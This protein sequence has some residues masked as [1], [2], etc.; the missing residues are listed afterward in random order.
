[1]AT[2]IRNGVRYKRHKW[3]QKLGGLVCARCRLFPSTVNI[4]LDNSEKAGETI[5]SHENSPFEC[6]ECYPLREE[7]VSDHKEV[8]SLLP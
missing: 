3:I 2:C 8:V 4:E 6:R 5:C 1:M 7:A